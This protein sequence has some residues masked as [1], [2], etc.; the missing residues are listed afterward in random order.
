MRPDEILALYSFNSLRTIER[1]RGYSLG[2]LRRQELIGALAARLL[3]QSDVERMIAA[4]AP[5]EL[6]ALQELLKAGGRLA[7]ERFVDALLAAGLIDEVGPERSRETIDR[8][9]ASTRRFGELCARLTARGLLFSEPHADGTLAGHYDLSPGAI[10]FLP[11]PAERALQPQLAPAAP[12]L[13]PA[14]PPAAPAPSPE[15][16][17]RLIVQPSYTVLILPPIDGPTLQQLQRIAE[18]VRLGEVAEFKLTQ[19]ALY[20]AAQ[21][22]TSVAEAVAFLEE[23]SEQPLPQNVRYSLDGW[24]RAFEQ[25]QLLRSAAL[26]EGPAAVLDELAL[27]P[28]IAPL[29]VRRVGSEWLLLRDAAAVE[30]ALIA[31]GEIPILTEYAADSVPPVTVSEDGLIEVDRRANHLLLPLALGRVAEPVGDGRFQL[32]PPSVR[33]AIAATPDGLTGLLKWLRTVA[34][35]L[36]PQLVARL[37]LWDTPADAVALERPLLLR[38]PPDLLAELRA[39]PEIGPLLEVEYRRESALV[40]VAPEA[41]AQLR[42]ALRARGLEIAGSSDER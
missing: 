17:G 38:L 4:L 19:A 8:I 42:A 36:P 18:P 26:L 13:A 25:A 39:F 7:R 35:A 31:A 30:Q 27:H 16:R 15:V 41:E 40:A 28:T 32:T 21:R 33:A 2:N 12:A 6:A 14:A 10:V 9:P 11:G 3:V 24:G 5:N 37:K 34:I 23:R 1:M 20:A 22:G 29:V